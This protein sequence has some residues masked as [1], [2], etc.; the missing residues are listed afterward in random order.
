[1]ASS[2][3]TDPTQAFIPDSGRP[4]QDRDHLMEGIHSH[5]PHLS[6]QLQAI[7]HYVLTHAD[8]IAAE[9]IQ[10]VAARCGVRPS[11]IVRFA[12]HFGFNGFQELK[13]TLAQDSRPQRPRLRH[14]YRVRL[15]PARQSGAT[16]TEAAFQCLDGACAGLKALRSTIRAQDLQDALAMLV[17]A[18]T[19][20]VAGARRAFPVAAYL[21][22]CLQGLTKPVQWVG[23]TGADH[24]G[25]L[26]GMRCHDALI[27]ISFAPYAAEVLHAV[28]MAHSVGTPVLALT[29]DGDSPLAG[30]A[31]VG[32][33]VQESAVQGFRAPTNAMALAHA[34][35]VAL[36]FQLELGTPGPLASTP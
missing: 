7:G 13:L 28:H 15:A 21:G 25:Q 2:Q 20:W 27:A 1:M 31:R 23:F 4:W 16:A 36:A 9:R 33:F 32:L 34:L 12:K 22:Y 14:D 19:L 5:M 11:A 35:F 10:D 6:R 26:R 29:D 8:Y 18:D 3:P 24:E 30:E 17:Q